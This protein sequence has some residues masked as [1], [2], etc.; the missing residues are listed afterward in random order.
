[1]YT[2]RFWVDTETTGLDPGKH[3][4]FQ[5]S[6]LIEEDN[7]IL[8]ERTLETR[9]DN[10]DEFE[11]TGEAEKIHGYSR[12]KIQSL[13]PEPEQYGVLVEDLRQFAENRLTI[14]GYNISFD[15]KFLKAFFRRNKPAGTQGSLFSRYFDYMYCD[16]MQLAQA[17]RI[18]GKLNLPS[19]E[20]V[21]VCAYLGISVQG[22]HNS[23]IDIRNTRAVFNRLI[24]L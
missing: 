22:A 10:H 3:F 14:T 1:M 23:M 18:A 13:A 9:P 6:Y 7:R 2:R 5:I 12:E 4:A 17:Q 16:V 15:I 8:L 21:K 24:S 19:I 20:L 11:F